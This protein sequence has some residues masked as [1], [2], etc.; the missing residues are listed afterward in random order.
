MT[1]AWCHDIARDAAVRA[2]E[3]NRT[4]PLPTLAEA[5]AAVRERRS[6]HT[7]GE[8]MSQG[9]RT[10]RVVLEITY[11]Q[12]TQGHPG[13][14]DWSTM[15]LDTG[16]SVRVVDGD[17]TDSEIRLRVERD[18]AIRE[19]EQLRE[20]LESVACR[21]ATAETAL[22]E[23]KSLD[24][25]R[26]AVNGAAW[27]ANNIA[28]KALEAASV[29]NRPETPDG[30]SQAASGGGE[31]IGRK[32]ADR[33]GR[34]ADRLESGEV[35]MPIG[36]PAQAASGGGE[37]EPVAWGVMVGGKIDR[38][39]F[40]DALFVDKATAER[41]CKTD[42]LQGTG[43]VVGLYPPPQPRGW[44]RKEERE[45]L[46]TVLREAKRTY[47]SKYEGVIKAVHGL[48]ARSSTPEVVRPGPWKAVQPF[49]GYLS[50]QPFLDQVTANRD[51]EW[52]A[53]LAAAGV[54]VK[55]VG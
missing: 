15:V 52:L 25:T 29:G 30:S 22:A 51:K 3:D 39:H 40:A 43:T 11:D 21:A 47:H 46:A 31:S 6:D 2:A 37:G 54:A 34:F 5:I 24:Y 8:E 27:Q 18:A 9:L 35:E 42:S 23:I 41:W 50:W 38:T 10:E 1:H 14:W 20:Q 16:E 7:K 12:E 44:L 55:E 36:P 48:L 49:P 33:L 4:G 53:S 45:A 13:T 32:L 26:A 28:A 17:I 19:R